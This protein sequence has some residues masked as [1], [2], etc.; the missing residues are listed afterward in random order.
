MPGSP[1]KA[2]A[3]LK[4]SPGKKNSLWNWCS[5]TGTPRAWTRKRPSNQ[6]N[7]GRLWT[8]CYAPVL[9]REKQ[10]QLAPLEHPG[11]SGV[12]LCGWFCFCFCCFGLAGFSLVF[13]FFFLDWS[14]QGS[15]QLTGPAR[16][17]WYRCF[18]YDSFRSNCKYGEPRDAK[19]VWLTCHCHRVLVGQER[20]GFVAGLG[21]VTNSVC[22]EMT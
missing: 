9:V 12:C 1:Q 17:P 2:F 10:E 14:T 22:G 8:V 15:L 6:E 16:P 5:Q 4:C 21:L 19:A 13:L 18:L 20:A 11:F 3:E 7:R